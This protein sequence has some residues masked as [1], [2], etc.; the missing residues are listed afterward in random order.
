MQ[1]RGRAFGLE[2][3][4]LADDDPQLFDKTEAIVAQIRERQRPGFLVIDT[5]RLGPHSKG[6]D[7]RD[8]AEKAAI[9]TRDP[10]WRRRRTAPPRRSRQWCRSTSSLRPR[11]RR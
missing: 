9:R 8:E 10:R 3:G 2:S 11:Q 4:R 5:R 7:L 1:E 6:D